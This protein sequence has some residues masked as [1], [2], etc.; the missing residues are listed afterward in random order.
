MD[1]RSVLDAPRGRFGRVLSATRA[2]VRE[3]DRQGKLSEVDRP[4]VALAL[5]L[6]G[7]VDQ[8]P[9][10]AQLAR[11]YRDTLVMLTRLRAATDD[12]ASGLIASMLAEVADASGLRCLTGRA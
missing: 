3:L 10:N 11:Q 12:D 6:A 1:L 8:T 7:A 5:S 9:G 4:M 2:A